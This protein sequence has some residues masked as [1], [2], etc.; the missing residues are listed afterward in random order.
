M[1]AE[2]KRDVP[3][4]IGRT[5]ECQTL[6][7][8]LTDVLAGTSRVMVLRGD[9]GVGKSALLAYVSAKVDGWRVAT[10]AGVESE[11]ELAFSGLHQLCA[12]MLDHLERLP[13]PLRNAL[14]TALGLSAGQPPDRFLLGL[15]TLT[16]LAEVAE[17]RPLIC[18]VDDAQ[19]LDDV[20]TQILAFVARRLLAERIAILCVARTGTGDEVL[21]GLPEMPVRGLNDSD[22]RAL[23]LSKVHGPLDAAVR[24]QIIAESRGNPL[25]LI[26]LPRAWKGGDLAGGFGSFDSQ[27]ISG[28]IEKSY[29]RRASSLPADTQLLLLA[30]AAEPLGDTAL[31]HRASEVLNLDLAAATPAVDAGLFNV[32]SRVQFTH[33][34]VRSAVYRSAASADRRRVH[35]VLA[36]VTNADTDPD[37]RAWHRAGAAAGPDEDVATELERSAERAR[38]RGGLAAA[39]GFLQRASVLS[40]DPARRTERI[41][42]AARANLSAGRF[43]AV[44]TLLANAEIRTL[45]EFQ[46]AQV[47]IVRG[48]VAMFSTLSSDASA[49][50]LRAARRLERLDVG[51]ARETY[52]DAWFAALISGHGS[53]GADLLDVSRAA[54]TAPG[55]AGAAGPS[56][57]LLDSL[58]MLMTEGRR[59]AAPLLQR[60]TAA[61]S[62]RACPAQA[63][64]RWNWLA[65]M[66]AWTLWDDESVYLLCGRALEASRASGALARLHIELSVFAVAALRCGDFASSAR[67]IMEIEAA[68]DAAGTIVGSYL[69]MMLA[70]YRGREAQARALIVTV[71]TGAVAAG[72]GTVIERCNFARAVLCNG[73]GKYEEALVAAREASDYQPQMYLSPWA[74]VELLEAATRAGQPAIA[75]AALERVLEATDHLPNDAA[76]GIAARSRALLSGA[77]TADRLFREAIERLGRSRL[78]P[79]LARAHLLYGERLRREH[80]RVDARAHLRTAYEQFTEIGMEAFAERARRELF[81]TGENV[82]KRTVEASSSAQLT[83]QERQI[84]LLARD[85]LSNPE[86]GAR[87]FL[88]PRTV[89][90]HLRKIFGKLSI[91]SRR[92]LRD[93]LPR[94]DAEATHG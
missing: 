24:D 34:L 79:E 54:R 90:W 4:L 63:I 2:E 59:A 1:L 86:I 68:T 58:A 8:M 72:Q 37:R 76:Q 45:D 30:A 85:G 89:E 13:V 47:D 10:A 32:G 67:A 21:P 15:A 42:A 43:D 74:A 52:L 73:L 3:E 55:P 7:R 27:P 64:I 71:T 12:P 20:S 28:M 40:S 33:P 44:R 22:S 69:P 39:A 6:D 41:L 82:R 91:D 57:L 92:Q 36:D 78:R 53:T 14:A 38:A 18:I 61:F 26:E 66:V 49:S 51:L 93:A 87:L 83:A 23:L 56:D 50:L 88:S 80:R 19:W 65:V 75:G 25:A 9:A 11:M 16:L 48:Q 81:A 94:G 84:A 62:D 35:S 46:Q 77:E 31:F 60:T 29:A 5:K 70:A 17:E